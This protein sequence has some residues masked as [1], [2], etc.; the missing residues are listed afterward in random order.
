MNPT[1]EQLTAYRQLTKAINQFKEALDDF[2]QAVT[3][4]KQT[5]ARRLHTRLEIAIDQFRTLLYDEHYAG[6]QTLVEVF[7]KERKSPP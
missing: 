7:T 3:F 1:P 6:S 2:D 5:K 4:P